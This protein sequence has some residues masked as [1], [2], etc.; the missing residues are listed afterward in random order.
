V[1]GLATDF[2]PAKRRRVRGGIPPNCWSANHEEAKVQEGQVGHFDINRGLVT[3][4]DF[5]EDEGPEDE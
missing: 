2:L 1:E 4:I 5:H 3:Q